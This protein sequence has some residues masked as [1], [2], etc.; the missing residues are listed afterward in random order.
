MMKHK[1]KQRKKTHSQMT[2]RHKLSLLTKILLKIATL[3][4]TLLRQV[5]IQRMMK[6][7]QH[8]MEEILKKKMQTTKRKKRCKMDQRRMMVK[9]RLSLMAQTDRIKRLM[10]KLRQRL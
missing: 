4:P 8:K 10:L 2:V 5:T 3:I 9:E 1:R 6:M 7:L